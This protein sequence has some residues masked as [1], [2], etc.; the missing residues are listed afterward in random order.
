MD[1]SSQRVSF[2]QNKSE[3]YI[4]L[5]QLRQNKDDLQESKWTKSKLWEEEME[6]R[7]HSD[8][9]SCL[10]WILTSWEM[11]KII[12]QWNDNGINKTPGQSPYPGVVYQ[13]KMNSSL[14][15][16]VC[17][18]FHLIWTLFFWF[19]LLFFDLERDQERIWSWACKEMGRL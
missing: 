1:N 6:S 17:F 15:L 4:I 7:S 11:E 14:C 2:R 8:S 5:E 18:S 3:T 12:L 9:R 13:D 19:S 16:F 10:Q